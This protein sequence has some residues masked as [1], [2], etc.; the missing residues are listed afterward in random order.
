MLTH[1]KMIL[2]SNLHESLIFFGPFWMEKTD[3]ADENIL[4]YY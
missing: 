1:N 3:I 4:N 2:Y